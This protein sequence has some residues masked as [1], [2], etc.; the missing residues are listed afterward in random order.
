MI[1]RENCLLL[2]KFTRPH[3]T[4]GTLLLGNR[5]LI[6]EDIRKGESV[7]VE[8]D[9]LLVPFFIESFKVISQEAA[10]VSVEGIDS[11]TKAK[12]FAGALVYIPEQKVRARKKNRDELPSLSGFTVIDTQ[13]GIV[14][15]A[16]EINPIVNN[17]LLSVFSDGR[18]FLIPVH[19]DIILEINRKKKEIRINAP[20]GLFDL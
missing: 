3:G 14:G 6:V 9:G 19:P 15:S 12:S 7:F 1:N 11:E 10:L 4:K 20:E 16:G 8:L 2:G 17:P 5:N 13:L 18:E